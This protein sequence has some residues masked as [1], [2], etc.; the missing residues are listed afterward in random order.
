MRKRSPVV[1]IIGL[2][3]D[4]I[5]VVIGVWAMAVGY[6]IWG[7]LVALFGGYLLMGL[8]A[9]VANRDGRAEKLTTAF[10]LSAFIAV[11]GWVIVVTSL[12][13][14][15]DGS[16]W[17]AAFAFAASASGLFIGGRALLR[18]ARARH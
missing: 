17:L 7:V 2:I 6:V 14:A 1:T 3:A 18:W 10:A 13:L 8:V 4:T 9:S 12:S 16:I 15:T 11:P 5:I